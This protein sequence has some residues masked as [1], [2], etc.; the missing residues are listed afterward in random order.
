MHLGWEPT[1]KI[2]ECEIDIYVKQINRV[3][4]LE[5]WIQRDVVIG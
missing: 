2:E 3:L 5:E 4:F 1:L